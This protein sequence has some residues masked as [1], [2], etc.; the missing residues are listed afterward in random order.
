[1]AHYDIK[2][3]VSAP[4]LAAALTCA[5]VFTPAANAA[6]DDVD[7]ERWFQVE[8][9]VFAQNKGDPENAEQWPEI[10]GTSLPS[11]LLE[12][13]DKPEKTEPDDNPELV[14]SAEPETT[15]TPLPVAYEILAEEEWQLTDVAKRLRR[16]TAFEPMLHIAWRQPT[17]ARGVARPVLLY[18]GMTDPLPTLVDPEVE[19]GLEGGQE[20][21]A[22]PP[23][24][25][26]FAN[27]QD[28]Q[29]GHFVGPPNPRFFGTL[30]VSV[31]RYLHFNV[32]LIYRAP[33]TQK[34]AVAVPDL[35]LWYDRPY[36]TLY[37]PQGPAYRL[38]E[39]QAMRGFQMKESRRMRSRELHYLDHPFFGIVVLITPVELPEPEV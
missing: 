2:F 10:V 1:M 7:E 4:L 27:E 38:K 16:A 9:I 28:T 6:S 8:I 20:L 35:E 11:G 22:T 12:L 26:Q 29:P 34:M 33:V 21:D 19:P 24:M 31:A 36:P 5:L 15:Q 25:P 17:L 37:E 13:S 32:D 14:E 18:D 23:L 3:R 39:W 30:S